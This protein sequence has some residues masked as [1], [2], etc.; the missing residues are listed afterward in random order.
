VL[1]LK[2]LRKWLRGSGKGDG[3]KGF[4]YRSVEK[5]LDARAATS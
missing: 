3:A 4:D 5:V 1:D 2:S